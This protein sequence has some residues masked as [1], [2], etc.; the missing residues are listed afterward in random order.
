MGRRGMP[1]LLLSRNY[2]YADG[3]QYDIMSLQEYTKGRLTS[4]ILLLTS[5][6]IWTLFERAGASAAHLWTLRLSAQLR[7]LLPESR[8]LHR[9]IM[10]NVI[11]IRHANAPVL[12]G[13]PEEGTLTISFNSRN[14]PMISNS[15][16]RWETGHAQIAPIPQLLLC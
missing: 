11:N 1:K 14:S 10:L 4:Y 12:V 7:S 16:G 5:I 9:I 6:G 2:Y 3:V 15:V 13:F 8:V